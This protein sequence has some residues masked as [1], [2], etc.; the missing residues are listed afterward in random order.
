MFYGH[1][2]IFILNWIKHSLSEV[3]PE[4]LW[5]SEVAPADTMLAVPDSSYIPVGLK[6]ETEVENNLYVYS[7]SPVSVNGA[8]DANILLVVVTSSPH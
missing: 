8:K 7:A 4:P 5:N 3:S 6:M 2:S 1:F